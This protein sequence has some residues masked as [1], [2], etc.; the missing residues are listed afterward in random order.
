MLYLAEVQKQRLAREAKLQILAIRGANGLWT[1][2]K[3]TLPLG[4][5]HHFENG[6]LVLVE[7]NSKR[8]IRKIEPAATQLVRYLEE[9]YKKLAEIENEKAE[10]VFWRHSL[11]YQAIELEKR[12]QNL[13]QKEQ[14]VE[15]K[16]K[17]LEQLIKSRKSNE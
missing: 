7:L 13:E 11:E 16:E 12:K 4:H 6:L 17:K 5:Q 10:I 2:F 1:P 14:L 9:A 8:D 3:E 15:A